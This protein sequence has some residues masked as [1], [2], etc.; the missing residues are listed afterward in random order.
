MSSHYVHPSAS[1]S[2]VRLHRQALIY[3]CNIEKRKAKREV[4]VTMGGGGRGCYT[5]IRRQE[6]SASV[7]QYIPCTDAN[8]FNLGATT[9]AEGRRELAQHSVWNSLAGGEKH[10]RCRLHVL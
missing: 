2:P 8:M 6:K 10:G 3:T 4:W 9:E 1:L 7:F 5:Q